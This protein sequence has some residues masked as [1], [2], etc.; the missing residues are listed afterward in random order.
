MSLNK[1]VSLES[2][3]PINMR[4]KVLQLE[5]SQEIKTNFLSSYDGFNSIGVSGAIIREAGDPIEDQDLTTK[6]YVDSA[7]AGGGGGSGV[8]NPM[9]ENLNANGYDINTANAIYTSTLGG[10]GEFQ[11]T[12]TSDVQFNSFNLKGTNYIQTDQ[13]YSSTQGDISVENALDM[14]TTNK[15]KNIAN[16][17]DSGDAIN[18]GQFDSS[19]TTL[20][21]DIA[22]NTNNI[23]GLNLEF[24]ELETQ[25]GINTTNITTNT[26]NITTNTN[27]IDTNITDIQTLTNSVNTNIANIQQNASDISTINTT[28]LTKATIND[29]QISSNTTWSSTK[30]NAEIG[31]ASSLIDFTG[32]MGSSDKVN[33]SLVNTQPIVGL[34]SRYTLSGSAV[35]VGQPMIQNFTSGE[36]TATGI[37]GVPPAWKFIG[38]ACNT[39]V[40][41]DDCNIVY[42][43]FCTARYDTTIQPST[44]AI[45]LTGVTTNTTQEITNETTFTDSGGTSNNYATNELYNITFD[46]GVG[47]TINYEIVSLGFEHTNT[48]LYDR[49]GFQF[50]NDGVNYSNPALNGFH[51]TNITTPSFGSYYVNNGTKT[52]DTIGNVFADGLTFITAYGGS[53]TNSTGFRYIKFFFQSDTS[54]QDLGWNIKLTPSTPY[55]VNYT[56]VP[57]DTPLYLDPN[58]LSKVSTNNANNFLVG[59][60]AYEDTSNDS[61]YIHVLAQNA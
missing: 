24:G 52:N 8:S 46:A 37:G 38:I 22:T 17:T 3:E 13:I 58:D 56:P 10:L 54:S 20:T 30:I 9:I 1:F 57:V 50:S 59:Y 6:V 25:Q 18:K 12:M 61:I 60:C 4:I 7:V 26:T 43:G 32:L 11:L 55:P 45:S 14:K 31:T 16:G 42:D 34:N 15:I 36:I 49:L 53:L 19:I 33:L 39:G 29:A 28:L 5:A 21:N 44:N 27:N 41:G 35:F 2:S 23:N 51:T 48:R 47:R 40:T